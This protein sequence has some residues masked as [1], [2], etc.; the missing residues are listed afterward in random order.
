M[1][2]RARPLV[3]ALALVALVLTGARP[4]RA[5]APARPTVA[6]LY[7]DYTGRNTELE[8]LRKGLAR[9]LISDLAAT[10]AFQIVER[11]RL[12]EVLAE[13]KLGQSKSFDAAAA[14]RVGKLLGA[15]YLVLGGYFELG[16][17]LRCDARV[18][19]VETGKVLKSLGVTRPSADFLE[20]EQRL[21][22]DLGDALAAAVGPAPPPPPGA[23]PAPP[24]ARPAP[25][26]RLKTAVAA[27]YGKALDAKDRGDT[28][29]AKA[30]LAA[31]VQEQPDF[32]LAVTDLAALA[33]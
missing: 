12:E 29:R 17:K 31:V 30:E 3:A 6:V 25:P 5:D 24:K 1:S 10:P 7:F 27:R 33:R 9:M 2:R 28:K 18:V 8:P 4:A 15:R 26:K 13:L 16:G 23:K 14:A 21:A 19:E 22:V 32:A 20:L 11:E